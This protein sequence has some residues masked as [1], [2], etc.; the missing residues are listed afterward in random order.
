MAKLK[1]RVKEPIL[2][3]D[4]RFVLDVSLTEFK[5]N[6]NK[7]YKIPDTPFWRER[8]TGENAMLELIGQVS[9][10]PKPKAKK[11]E[12]VKGDEKD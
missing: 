1:V 10:E 12:E 8:A 9:D 11:A 7:E 5:K 4:E 3:N 2:L 6:P